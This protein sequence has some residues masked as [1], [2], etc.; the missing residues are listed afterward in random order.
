MAAPAGSCCTARPQPTIREAAVAANAMCAVLYASRPPETRGAVKGS[1]RLSELRQFQSN[2][3][4][5]SSLSHEHGKRT[6]VN[7]RASRLIAQ[8]RC[9]L[10]RIRNLGPTFSQRIQYVAI[11]FGTQ[12]PNDAGAD[13]H[14]KCIPG[15]EEGAKAR[16][17]RGPR[18]YNGMGCLM[19]GHVP[20]FFLD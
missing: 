2:W 8:A 6:S 9:R 18:S 17:A 16:A 12:L 20:E 4:C 14:R 19:V 10:Y 13:F 15:T 11:F 7:R 3:A 5:K 1:F